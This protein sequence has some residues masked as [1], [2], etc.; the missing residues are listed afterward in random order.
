MRRMRVMVVGGLVVVLA[1]TAAATAAS[2]RS[3]AAKAK[4]LARAMPAAAAP[5]APG[6]LAFEPQAPY[7]AALLVDRDSGQVLF[8][9]NEHLPW[10]PASMTKMMTVLIAMERVRDRT[11]ALDDTITTSKWASKIGGS[12]VYLSEGERFSLRDLLASIM[13][14]SANDAAVAVAERIAGSTDGFVTLMNERAKALGMNDTE[15][16]SVHGLPPARGQ[17]PDLMS[18]ADL[19]TLGRL[20][21]AFPEV[22]EWAKTSEAPFRDGALQM[23][24][25]NHLVR[26]FAGADG[27]KTGFYVAAGFE[28]TATATRDGLRL[29]AVVLGA[30]TKR[31]CF[32][33]AA[34][35]LASGF[36]SYRAIDAAKAGTPVGTPIAVRSGTVAQVVGLASGDLRLT[37]PRADATKV[38]VEVKVP[39]EVAA[40]V[41]KGQVLGEVVVTRGGESLGR[42]EVVAASDIESTSWWSGWF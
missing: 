12:Q 13:I 3:P 30:S 9:K 15:F 28:V 25:T 41:K 18:A 37:V 7:T 16:H 5:A 4:S 1:G 2:A 6:A 8:A 42:V 31:G 38:K 39:A 17:L 14:A 20:L 36:A 27:L 22:M 26:T 23:R 34:K 35:L 32:D 40:P 33:E 10:P 21:V 24:N 29:M 11:L 19:V